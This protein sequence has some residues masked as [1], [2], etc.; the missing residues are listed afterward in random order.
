MRYITT[1]FK[2]KSDAEFAPPIISAKEPLLLRLNLFSRREIC[3]INQMLQGTQLITL[4]WALVVCRRIIDIAVDGHHLVCE[5]IDCGI[6]NYIAR[7]IV[8]NPSNIEGM[9][10]ETFAYDELYRVCVKGEKVYQA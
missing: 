8:V 3:Q 7:K 1:L 9:I 6:A 2:Q 10:T 4:L 5:L